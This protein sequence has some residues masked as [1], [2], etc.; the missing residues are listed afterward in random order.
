MDQSINQK[1]MTLQNFLQNKERDTRYSA[2]AF[3]MS[4]EM[5]KLQNFLLN[6]QSD[7]RYSVTRFAKSTFFDVTKVRNAR[8]PKVRSQT[9]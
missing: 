3:L 6:K 7:I 9:E 4:Q 1:R 8:L 5:L 2:I